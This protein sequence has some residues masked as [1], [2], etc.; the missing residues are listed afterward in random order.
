[1]SDI[2]KWIRVTYLLL[3]SPKLDVGQ[4]LFTLKSRTNNLAFAQLATGNSTKQSGRDIACMKPQNSSFAVKRGLLSWDI[5]K[6]TNPPR[7]PS[8]NACRLRSGIVGACAALTMMAL[9][10]YRI[11]SRC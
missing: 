7:I 1:M 5:E 10:H 8:S 3:R 4:V 2:R 6:Q 11:C 9:H